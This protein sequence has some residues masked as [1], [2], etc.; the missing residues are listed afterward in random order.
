MKLKELKKVIDK[1]CRKADR[2]NPD[3]EI[4]AGRKLYVI[5]DI[6]QFGVIPDVV[7]NIKRSKL[8]G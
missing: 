2:C 6:S 4:W 3:I 1:C 5:D 8:E 7:I